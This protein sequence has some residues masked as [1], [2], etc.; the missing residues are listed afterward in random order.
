MAD[1]ASAACFAMSNRGSAIA[2]MIPINAQT[3]STSMRVNP[4]CFLVRTSMSPHVPDAEVMPTSAVCVKCLKYG[5]S[6]RH[7]RQGV[8]VCVRGRAGLT[9]V[10]S[11]PVSFLHK[12]RNMKSRFWATTISFA[13]ASSLVSAQTRITPPPNKYSPAQDVEL[14][15]KAADEAR[16]QLPIMRDDAVTSYVENIGRRLVDVIPAELRHPEF[17]YTFEA[18]NVR[19]I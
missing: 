1:D 18:V 8:T 4:V 3:K 2:E 17:R 14:G 10:D 9:I 11:F 19:E 12:L 7:P 5:V 16:N 6:W 13:L 15:R